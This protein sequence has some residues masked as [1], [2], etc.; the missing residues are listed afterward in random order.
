[1]LQLLCRDTIW[2]VR[3]RAESDGKVTEDDIEK[4]LGQLAN[5]S[6]T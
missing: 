2:I 5:G 4:Y 6:L 3:R 1:M